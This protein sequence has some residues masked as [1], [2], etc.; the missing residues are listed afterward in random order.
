MRWGS[1]Q[2]RLPDSNGAANSLSSAL[3]RRSTR[4]SG[5]ELFRNVAQAAREDRQGPEAS[6]LETFLLFIRNTDPGSN[7]GIPGL[8]IPGGLGPSE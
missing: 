3:S 5:A 7:T 6:A 2:T 4:E 8:V 1:G